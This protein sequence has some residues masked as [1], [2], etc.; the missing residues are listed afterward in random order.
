MTMKDVRRAHAKWNEARE[1]LREEFNKVFPVGTRV[2]WLHN[3]K[4]RQY[5]IVEHLD[6]WSGWGS[7]HAVVV[8]EKTKIKIHFRDDNYR[9]MEL[10]PAN[11]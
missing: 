9:Y 4:Y 8:N 5:G 10:E 1:K 3:G 6:D 7:L 2:T 11:D